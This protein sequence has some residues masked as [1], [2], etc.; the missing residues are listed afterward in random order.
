MKFFDCN[1][2]FGAMMA[3]PPKIAKTAEELLD[4]M[5]F[6]GINKALVYHAAQRDDSPVVG[7]QL[8][9]EETKG[10][11]RLHRSWAILPHQTG[12]L[13]PPEELV[14]LMKKHEVRALRA[15]PSEHRYLM[16]RTSLGPLYDLMVEKRI[17]LF[18]SIRESA[19]GVSGWSLIDGM[20]AENP[21]LTLV[22]MDQGTWGQDRYFRPLV[23]KYENFYMDTSRY[24]LSGG[25]KAFCEKYGSDRILFGTGFPEI[26]IG[27]VLLALTHADISN[28]EKEAIAC[29]NL[30]RLLRGVRF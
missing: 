10:F 3:P 14:T 30:E 20:L 16:T 25:I 5:D 26:K 27:G 22:V 7:N 2:S 1:A 9:V 17:P 13:P 18:I 12:E 29:G 6:C 8:L 19:G 24:E 28:K 21:D 15:F 23:E 11:D 4:E